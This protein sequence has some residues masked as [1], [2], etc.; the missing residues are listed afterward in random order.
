MHPLLGH[1]RASM[2]FHPRRQ[3]KFVFFRDL[4]V[5]DAVDARPGAHRGHQ[6]HF[7]AVSMRFSII[8]CL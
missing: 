6:P 5:F 8:K 2:P 3:G 1:K 7:V 4:G